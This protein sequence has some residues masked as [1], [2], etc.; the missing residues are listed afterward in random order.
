MQITCPG[1]GKK[2]KVPPKVLQSGGKCPRCGNVLVIAQVTRPGDESWE[3]P[4]TLGEH[5]FSGMLALAAHGLLFLVLALI[6]TDTTQGGNPEPKT[7]KIAELPAEQLILTEEGNLE[8]GSTISSESPSDNDLTPSEI[9][10]PSAPLSE[11]GTI[12]IP[13]AP[14]GGVGKGG[15]P[16][17]PGSLSGGG[18]MGGDSWKGMLERLRRYGLDI[19]LVFD[20]TGSMG[21]EINQVKMQISKIGK[22]LFKMVPKT[23]IGI[24]T[25]RDLREAYVVKGL[26]LSKKLSDVELYLSGITANG[27][28]DFPEAVQEGLKWVV[29]YNKFRPRARKV[30]L[31]FGDAPPH[32]QDLAECLTVSA[33]FRKKL[34]GIVSTVT[35]RGMNKLPEFD[36]I[37]ESGGGESFLVADHRLIMQQLIV[38]VFGSKHKSKVLEAFRIFER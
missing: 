13:D 36:Q 21:G 3:E 1:C 35:C 29:G 7:I 30:I 26:P 38:L 11:L 32:R 22:T 2:C 31:L 25:Y 12:Q 14:G 9:I 27:G 5:A 4:S 18:S 28:G 24:C 23:R 34:K 33:T 37:A 16:G 19:V 6:P 20:S 15:L 17:N 10:M 8:A